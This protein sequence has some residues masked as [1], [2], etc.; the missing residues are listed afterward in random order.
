MADASE[1]APV[2]APAEGEVAE[3][4]AG[5][6]VETPATDGAEAPAEGEAA[7]GG[8]GEAD[9]TPVTDGAEAAPVE[10]DNAEA[11]GEAAS[12]AEGEVAQAEAAADSAAAEGGE[13]P[14]G[15]GDAPAP[16]EAG[17]PA[18]EAAPEKVVEYDAEKLRFDRGLPGR[19]FLSYY[20]IELKH[21]FGWETQKRNNLHRLGDNKLLSS[22]GN[23]LLLLDL[24]TL[25]QQFLLGI[26]MGGIGA[27]TVHPS[28]N[29]FAVG[30]RQLGGAPNIY[31]Y[32]YPSLKLVHVLANGTERSFS[33]LRFS[34]DGEMCRRHA[35]LSPTHLGLAQG[36]CDAEGQGLLS[37]GLQ[38]DFLTA[39]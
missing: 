15:N 14:A 13:T 24:D 9:E 39:F 29:Y 6:A 11:S 32:E 20:S 34:H 25:E 7:G 10:G 3:G 27:I 12:A 4:G 17:A 18:V 30:E 2:E 26:D 36:S 37:G 21:S 19:G 33:D 23:S 31:I 35:R 28:G 5:E 8:A 1:E 38:R 22:A 16:A